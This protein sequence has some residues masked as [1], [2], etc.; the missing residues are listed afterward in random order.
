M[1][2]GVIK[3][4]PI[5]AAFYGG[6]VGG[7]ATIDA[8]NVPT[9]VAVNYDLQGVNMG[10]LL[11]DMNGKDTMTGTLN[12]KG[13]LAFNTSPQKKQMLQSVNGDGQMNL[14]NGVIKGIDLPYFY[15]MGSNLLNRG[16]PMPTR[17]NTGQ[18]DF[19]TTTAHI[20]INKGLLTNK[21]LVVLNPGLYGAGAG[22]VNFVSDSIDYRFSLQGATDGNP[23]GPIIPLQI[24][25]SLENPTIGLDM[26]AV[27]GKVVEGAIQGAI[28]GKGGKGIGE[29]IFK[30]LGQ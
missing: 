16:N 14:K 15:A 3:L 17:Q 25:G 7:N 11:K 26:N 20:N 23:S 28:Q 13:K 27:A 19:T 24:R 12:M 21:D 4:N 2:A 18:T 22:T 6:T 30:A 1:A 5:S 10:N 8:S 29:Q 9:R